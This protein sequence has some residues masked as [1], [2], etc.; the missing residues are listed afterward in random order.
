M[1]Q[2]L[3]WAAGGTGFTFFMT[4]L[5]AAVVFFFRKKVN[6][7]IQR[8]FLGFA[9]GVMI[10]ASIW[11]L[12]IPAID[13]AEKAGGIGW[14]PAA[15]GFVLGILFLVGLDSLLPHL[16][17]GAKD[18]E[19]VPSSFKR[20][21][22]LVFAVT[23]HN[24]PEGMAVGLS[25]CARR[26]KRRRPGALQRGHGARHRRG[27]PEFSGGR[28]HLSAA[29][30]GGHE[31][32]KSLCHGQPFR[33]SR[34]GFRADYRAHRRKRRLADAL[35]A[36]VRRGRNDVCG[37][38]GADTTGAFGRAFQYRD[39]RRNGGL[40]ADDGARC[41]IGMTSG[42]SRKGQ[43]VCLPF[44]APHAGYQYSSFPPTLIVLK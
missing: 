25:V 40:S 21:T 30:A 23:L 1:S 34:T 3:L 26:A 4:T 7:G 17:P 32:G 2:A 28:S 8:I 22:L 42:T 5:G 14:I 43:A 38:G 18:P 6:I 31:N 15:G 39:A 20:T 36:C 27:H 44:F 41:R 24:I 19:G 16:H 33:N 12:L 11:S 37:R 13:Q 10:A 35:D 9:A 29:A